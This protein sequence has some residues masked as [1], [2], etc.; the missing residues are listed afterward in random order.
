M[1]VYVECG[2][3]EKKKIYSHT[4]SCVMCYGIYRLWGTGELIKSING[5]RKRA[6]EKA[7]QENN[8]RTMTKT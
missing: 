2:E 6:D 4:V 7:G 3:G 1:G 8:C 5:L